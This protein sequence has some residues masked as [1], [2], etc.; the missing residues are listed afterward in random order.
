MNDENI[1]MKVKDIVLETGKFHEEKNL[2]M[3]SQGERE[4]LITFSVFDVTNYTTNPK[5]NHPTLF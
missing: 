5:D 3:Y 4:Y 1:R 2:I